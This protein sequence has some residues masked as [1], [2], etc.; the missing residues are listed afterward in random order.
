MRNRNGRTP[1]PAAVN[2][3]RA[4]ARA[5][6]GTLRSRLLALETTDPVP[7]LEHDRAVAAAKGLMNACLQCHRLDANETTLRPVA[8]AVPPMRAASFNH[9]PHVLQ[10]SCETCH[11][12]I[13]SSRAGV[14]V[15]L[16]AVAT[17]Q[18]CH[19][20]ARAPDTC[21]TCHAYHPKSAVDLMV[22]AR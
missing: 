9:R 15:N 12:S 3:E 19:D 22:A 20:G 8:A 10:T 18:S 17:C 21:A 4:N 13:A 5:A 16:P 14:D 2:D 1:V 7:P 11:K 6:V